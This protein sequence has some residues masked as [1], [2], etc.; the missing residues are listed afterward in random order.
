M[1]IADVF[2]CF[3]SA[4][5]ERNN[6]GNDR[7]V[8]EIIY[9]HSLHGFIK[10]AQCLIRLFLLFLA[11]LN[12]GL[13]LIVGDNCCNLMIKAFVICDSLVVIGIIGYLTDT[14]KDIALGAVVIAK[15]C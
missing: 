14:L 2:E 11:K 5:Q 9:L 12:G 6:G 8:L 3:Y 1:I 15:K 10:I 7:D 13:R 4:E